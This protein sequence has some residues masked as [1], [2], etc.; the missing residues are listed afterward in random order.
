M[1]VKT[2]CDKCQNYEL[3]DDTKDFCHGFMSNE[4]SIDKEYFNERL[5]GEKTS[6]KYF[7]KIIELNK[8]IPYNKNKSNE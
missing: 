3:I 6:C 5:K 8:W 2:I 1:E 7:K 4:V